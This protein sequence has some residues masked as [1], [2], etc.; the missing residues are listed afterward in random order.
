MQAASV[1]S[2]SSG[3]TQSNRGLAVF[4]SN[5][6]SANNGWVS[7]SVGKDFTSNNITPNANNTYNL[8]A[9]GNLYSNVWANTLHGSLDAGSITGTL[10]LSHGGTG[11]T[12]ASKALQNLLDSLGI[13]PTPGYVLTTYGEGNY[14]WGPGGG[15]GGSTIQGT[16]INSS[17]ITAT[18]T[19]G[20]TIFSAPTYVTGAD[21][22]RVYINGVRQ[23]IDN[24]D[25]TETSTTSFTLSTGLNAGDQVLAEVD[26]YVIYDTTAAGVSFVPVGTISATNVQDGMAQLDNLKMPKAGGTFSGDVTMSGAALYL[27][28][29]TTTK[30]PIYLNAGSVLTTPTAGALEWDGANLYATVTSGPTRQTVAYQSWV[31]GLADT[32]ATANTVAKRDGSADLYANVFHGTATSANYA[33]LAE[34]YVTDVKYAPGTVVMVGGD[35]EV[36]AVTGPD[37]WVLGVIST[38]PAHLMNASANGQPIALTGRVPCKV[39]VAVKKGDPLYPDVDGGATNISN[40][41]HPFGFALETTLVP[42]LVEC[43]VK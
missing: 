25:Y 27:S 6:F 1:L 15:G 26:G 33:D 43:V 32:A 13:N 24:G 16:R 31:N 2:T 23:N 19:D 39:N 18:A 7:L 41:R 20:Q 38:N 35:E 10:P 36:T 12:S 3:V 14:Q 34:K 29:G 21:Q 42:G 22:L 11:A 37:C 30:A 4:D 40:G 9:S 8:G 5:Y 28:G 17:R